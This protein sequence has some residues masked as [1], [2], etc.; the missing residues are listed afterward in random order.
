[1]LKTAT[2]TQMQNISSNF[3]TP[4]Q[5]T[6]LLKNLSMFTL[7]KYLINFFLD[8]LKEPRIIYMGHPSCRF[9]DIVQFIQAIGSNPKNTIIL[10]GLP[11]HLNAPAH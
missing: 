1:M 7:F 3:C 10:I 9:G 4:P 6:K 2:L 5:K 8:S 11:M